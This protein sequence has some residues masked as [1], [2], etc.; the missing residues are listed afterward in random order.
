MNPAIKEALAKV[1]AEET[2]LE[3]EA[4]RIGAEL[5]RIKQVKAVLAGADGT[6]MPAKAS[7]GGLKS[8]ILGVLGNKPMAN[9][10]IRDALAKSDY[11][12]SLA[13]LHVTKTL[14]ALKRAGKVRRIGTG[15]KSQYVLAPTK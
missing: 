1:T 11:T 10:A 15:T 13:P 6:S 7:P 12:F 14:M 4:Q 8:A 9:G 2:R 5:A 3:A